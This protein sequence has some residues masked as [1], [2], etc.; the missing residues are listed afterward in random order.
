MA[1]IVAA[2]AGSVISGMFAKSAAGKAREAQLK[3]QRAE[4]A[5]QNR[6]TIAA[7]NEAERLDATSASQMRALAA[8]RRGRGGLSFVGPTTGLK[9]SLGG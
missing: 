2:I 1:Q 7:Q 3:A 4:E 5:V 6:Q 9:T 8:G